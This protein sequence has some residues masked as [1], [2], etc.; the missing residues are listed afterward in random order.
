MSGSHAKLPMLF[1]IQLALAAVIGIIFLLTPSKHGTEHGDDSSDKLKTASNNLAPV[2]AVAVKDDK[3]TAGSAK[4]RSGDVVYK[5]HCQS[6]H[7]TGIAN[8]PKPSDKAAWEPRVANGLDALLKTAIN[9]KG[10]MPARGGNP[11]VT[12]EELHNS[13]LFMTK[14]AG[15]DLKPSNTKKEKS[16]ATT[17][18]KP[19]ITEEKPSAPVEAETAEATTITPAESPSAPS[20]PAA[21]AAPETTGAPVLARTTP[22]TVTTPASTHDNP[23]ATNNK[24]GEKVYKTACFACHDTGVAN[25][26]KIGDKAAWAARIS[27]GQEALYTTALKGKGAM[28]AKGGNAS[29]SDDTVKAAVDFMVSKSQ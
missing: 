28:P 22:N 23:V 12:D 24:E 13:I 20:A 27:T 17:E 10:A 29:L 6:C 4:A 11:A 1:W 15:F 14:Q 16:A 8:A 5:A 26:P 2:G 21:P 25:A 19:A 7:A 9:G 3:A 18:T